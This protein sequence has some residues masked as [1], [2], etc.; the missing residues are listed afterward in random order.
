MLGIPSLHGDEVTFSPRK[1]VISTNTERHLEIG[2]FLLE[3]EDYS[4]FCGI[5]DMIPIISTISYSSL[6]SISKI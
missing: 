3:I 5:T 6:Y 4:L 2:L 1:R